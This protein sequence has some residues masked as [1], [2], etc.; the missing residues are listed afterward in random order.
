MLPLPLALLNIP[1]S[2]G[3][4]IDVVDSQV[5]NILM[6]LEPPEDWRKSI[7]QAMS[8][9]LG[10]QSLEERLAEIRGTIERMDFRWDQG[11]ITDKDDFMDKRLKLQHELEKLTPVPQDDLERAADLLANFKTH[12]EAC[13]SDVEAQHRLVKLIVERVYL[14]DQTVVAMTMSSFGRQ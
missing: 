5:V 7:T 4:R 11:F 13:G 3:V 1:A 9:I 14:H 2:T 12:W 6:Q 10:E 8:E